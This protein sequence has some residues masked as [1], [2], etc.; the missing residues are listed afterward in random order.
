MSSVNHS[1]SA[2]LYS[3]ALDL[4]KNVK[5]LETHGPQSNQLYQ[6]E[7]K[8]HAFSPP[9]IYQHGTVASAILAELPLDFSAGL[10]F[11]LLPPGQAIKGLQLWASDALTRKNPPA[12]VDF[13]KQR[14]M[15]RPN[16]NYDHM[17]MN[18]DSE[19]VP[20]CQQW[21]VSSLIRATWVSSSYV[22]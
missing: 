17:T 8:A 19:K 11:A 6:N 16:D 21:W 7:I 20:P 3:K 9:I 2:K 18:Y 1:V 13:S 12:P 10:I 4:T 5:A 15:S 14:G 22:V